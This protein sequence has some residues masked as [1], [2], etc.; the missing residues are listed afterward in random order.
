[1]FS[2]FIYHRTFFHEA[3]INTKKKKS[4]EHHWGEGIYSNVNT[5]QKSVSRIYFPESVYK[6]HLKN[7]T[8]DEGSSL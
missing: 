8:Y 6:P 3:T 5:A 4:L 2:K 1:M 7:I